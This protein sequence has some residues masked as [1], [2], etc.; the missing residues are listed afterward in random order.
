M[1]NFGMAQIRLPK[2]PVGALGSKDPGY[3]CAAL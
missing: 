1:E 3:L 2:A